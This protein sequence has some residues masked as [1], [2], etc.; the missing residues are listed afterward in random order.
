MRNIKFRYDL[1][2]RDDLL[3][4]SIEVLSGSVAL[5]SLATIKRT[6]RFTIKENIFKDVDYLNDRIR[7]I[8]ILDNVEYPM[9]VFLLPSPTRKKTSQGIIREIEAYDKTQILLEDKVVDRYYIR[10]DTN[11]IKAITRIINSANI[12]QVMIDPAD[13]KL[14]RDREFEPGTS[15]LEIVNTLL[16]ECNYTS[17]YSDRNGI[18]KA[19]KYVLPNYRNADITYSDGSIKNPKL[20]INGLKVPYTTNDELDLFNVANIFV[21]VASNAENESL[22]ALYKNVSPTSP[23]SIINRRRNIVDYRTVSDIADQ[24]TLNNYVKRLAYNATNTY[25]KI[26]F[27]TLVNPR[28]GYNECIY[29]EDKALGISSKY[30]ETSWEFN[31]Q[32]GSTMKHQA[33]RVIT[34]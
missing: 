5:N 32:V 31:L 2:N 30:I 24:T 8:V 16:N 20:D 34:I 11:Y 17:L 26:S 6:A 10:K 3:K 13:F 7:P 18:L 23:T 33:R 14:K 21:V 27:E 29:V 9:G 25:Q 12:Y 22:R 28:H 1:L 19:K 15:K 4:D